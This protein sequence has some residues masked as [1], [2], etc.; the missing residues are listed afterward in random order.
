MNLNIFKKKLT[1]AQITQEKTYT[2]YNAISEETRIMSK[3]F[4]W[5]V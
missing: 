5:E 2:I 4:D 1:K 3:C